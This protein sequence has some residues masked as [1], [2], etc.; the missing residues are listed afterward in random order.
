MYWK[1][2]VISN[3]QT[4]C[5][6]YGFNTH[7][8]Y[9]IVNPNSTCSIEWKVLNQA[10]KMSKC[11]TYHDLKYHICCHT[12]TIRSQSLFAE[13]YK[14]FNSCVFWW[15]CAIWRLWFLY[16]YL[17]Y[18]NVL[19][20]SLLICC[21]NNSSLVLK[22]W[23]S[24]NWRSLLVSER[25]FLISFEI[26]ETPL[27]CWFLILHEIYFCMRVTALAQIVYNQ[28]IYWCEC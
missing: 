18:V 8:D 12:F 26:F 6:K 23:N 20:F 9:E 24:H 3:G 5:K 1:S 17:S 28:G 21:Q 11:H 13:R 16:F 10:N 2:F 7:N 4:I 15:V 22:S 27:C 25:T 19:R 14:V